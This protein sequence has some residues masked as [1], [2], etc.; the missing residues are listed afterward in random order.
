MTQARFSK[1]RPAQNADNPGCAPRKGRMWGRV[2]MG[3]RVTFEQFN[4]EIALAGA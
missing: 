1:S 3:L 2:R 4:F